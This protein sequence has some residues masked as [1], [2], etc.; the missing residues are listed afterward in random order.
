[1]LYELNFTMEDHML[2][3]LKDAGVNNTALSPLRVQCS[4]ETAR[5]L[6]VLLGH[7]PVNYLVLEERRVCPHCHSMISDY[8]SRHAMHCP[9]CLEPLV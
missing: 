9:I 6:N 8:T 7:L 5:V 4:K 1:M 2:H 3:S